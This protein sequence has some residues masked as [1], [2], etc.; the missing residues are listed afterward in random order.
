M[1]WNENAVVAV[2]AAKFGCEK[3]HFW[4]EPWAEVQI[5]GFCVCVCIWGRTETYHHHRQR[6]WKDS[7]WLWHGT[8]QCARQACRFGRVLLRGRV[9]VTL[10]RG[11]TVRRSHLRRSCTMVSF[12]GVSAGRNII[13]KPPLFAC[14]AGTVG[15]ITGEKEQGWSLSGWS[16]VGR[17]LLYSKTL[18]SFFCCCFFCPDFVY[19]LG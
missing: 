7:R 17:K 6:T 10:R 2:H 19:A 15:F 18:K 11:E 13:V 16:C 5:V 8:P 12:W 4:R 3:W 1:I 14:L 9:P